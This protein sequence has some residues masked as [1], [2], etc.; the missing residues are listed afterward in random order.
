MRR[1]T[2]S[3][4]N[5]HRI[6]VVVA[7]TVQNPIHTTEEGL[8]RLAPGS[9]TIVQPLGR[10]VAQVAHVVSKVRVKM[11][12][13]NVYTKTKSGKLQNIDQAWE[14]ITTIVLQC[15]DSLELGHVY[16]LL[17]ESDIKTEIFLDTNPEYGPGEVPTAIATWPVEPE[18]VVGI[19]DYLP[20][21]KG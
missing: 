19:T 8:L 14:P 13:D 7:A 16:D 6:Y 20:L 11:S 21:L 12:F 5:K 2:I 1:A 3:T 17:A 18:D 15:R 4:F 10:Q 9:K